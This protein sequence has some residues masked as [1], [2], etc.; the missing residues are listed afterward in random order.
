M[1]EKAEPAVK[2][3]L[4]SNLLKAKEQQDKQA[5]ASDAPSRGGFEKP[6]EPWELSDGCV[7]LL[8]ELSAVKPAIAIVMK[9][10]PTLAELSTLTHFK[11]SMLL[12]ENIMTS[13]T[14]IAQSLG[15]AKFRPF[16]DDPSLV[17]ALF[18][19]AKAESQNRA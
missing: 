10:L 11:Q 5:E 14:Q 18:R 3:Y 7:L 19:N 8:R 15:K 17:D 16:L 6:I 13:L 12:A 4:T 2:E 1:P 9:H